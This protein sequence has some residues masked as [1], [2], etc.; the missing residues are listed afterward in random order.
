MWIRD[1]RHE[2]ILIVSAAKM[3][4]ILLTPLFKSL[5]CTVQY[6]SISLFHLKTVLDYQEPESQNSVTCASRTQPGASGGG[7][8]PACVKQALIAMLKTISGSQFVC[9]TYTSACTLPVEFVRAR[10]KKGLSK[11]AH[12]RFFWCKC[13]STHEWTSIFCYCRS[14][15]QETETEG[16]PEDG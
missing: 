6:I 16:H 10:T 11:Q 1:A 4:W 12:I 14:E 7:I 8:N 3:L 9:F 15:A 13:D 5:C 2:I